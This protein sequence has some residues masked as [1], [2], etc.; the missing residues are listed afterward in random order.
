MCVCVLYAQISICVAHLL[1]FVLSWLMFT[2]VCAKVL[3]SKEN[4]WCRRHKP[5]HV[6]D[7]KNMLPMAW[8]NGTSLEAVKCGRKIAE[9][10]LAGADHLTIH[11][12]VKRHRTGLLRQCWTHGECGKCSESAA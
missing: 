9:G 3:F 11:Q 2:F 1:Q 10:D 4:S 12:Q 5:R 7:M 6:Y 8:N